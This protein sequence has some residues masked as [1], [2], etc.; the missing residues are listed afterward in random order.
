[1]FVKRIYLYCDGGNN[2]PIE[3]SEAFSADN[4]AGTIKQ[5]K[6]MAKQDGWVFKGRKGYCPICAAQAEK[7]G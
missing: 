6:E 5:Y 3:G 4:N 2:C 7:E 1:M